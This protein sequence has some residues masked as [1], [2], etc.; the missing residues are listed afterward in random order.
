MTVLDNAVTARF[1][2]LPAVRSQW[3]GC[4]RGGR[5]D[6][7]EAQCHPGDTDDGVADGVV[8]EPFRRVGVT[9]LPLPDAVHPCRAG[10]PQQRRQLPVHTSTGPAT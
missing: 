4:S 3:N 9:I 2:G 5:R 1:C 10:R 7:R 6:V 8:N